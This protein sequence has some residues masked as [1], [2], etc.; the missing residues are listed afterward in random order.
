MIFAHYNYLTNT[1]NA[2]TARMKPLKIA[3]QRA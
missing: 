2:Q 3:A 1:V